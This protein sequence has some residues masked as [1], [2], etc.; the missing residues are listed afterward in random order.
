MLMY[1]EDI[2]DDDKWRWFILYDNVF[3]LFMV[4]IS[5]NNLRWYIMII[6]DDKLWI[7]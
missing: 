1:N 7:R 3:Y 6:F 4:I 2:Y 5:D